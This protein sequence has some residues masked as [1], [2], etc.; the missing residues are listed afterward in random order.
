MGPV[1]PKLA[2][3]PP[4]GEGLCAKCGGHRVQSSDRPLGASLPTLLLAPP[5]LGMPN[6]CT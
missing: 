3:A 2:G 5:C 1:V 6:G 4:L